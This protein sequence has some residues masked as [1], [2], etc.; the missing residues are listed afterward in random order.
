[1]AQHSQLV[2]CKNITAHALTKTA[3][4]VSCLIFLASTATVQ[5]SSLYKTKSSHL[6]KNGKNTVSSP[7]GTVNASTYPWSTIG[8]LNIGGK[9]YCTAVMIGTNHV[10]TEAN[11]LY[12]KAE[13][14]W[15]N[16]DE[17]HFRAGYQ[18]DEHI[19]SSNISRVEISD[20]F[21]PE[22]PDSLAS[23]AGNWA[24]ITLT[25]PLGQKTGWLGIKGLNKGMRQTIKSGAAKMFNAGYHNGWEHAVRISNGCSN[26]ISRQKIPGVGTIP[27]R[28]QKVHQRSLP[29]FYYQNGSYQ[30]VSSAVF[31]RNDSPKRSDSWVFASLKNART[32]WGNSHRP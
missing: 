31:S 26:N 12:N 1:M 32:T 18:H 4:V 20:S 27:C 11:C 8:R 15:W 21:N 13:N 25:D 2:Q 19:A 29:T 16:N 23:I 7:K 14:R 6:G 3:L 22:S 5:A 10:Y 30:L 9:A 28:G 17:L 24:L